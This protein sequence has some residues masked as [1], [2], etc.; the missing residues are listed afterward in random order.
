[1]IHQGRRH[2]RRDALEGQETDHH[3]WAARC[4]NW[5]VHARD[6]SLIV[7]SCGGFSGLRLRRRQ[8]GGGLFGGELKTG[9]R[10]PGY[11]YALG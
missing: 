1:M 2:D 9:C 5:L 7:S 10:S 4:D 3:E 11:R 6:V 8:G